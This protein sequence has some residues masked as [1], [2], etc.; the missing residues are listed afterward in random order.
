MKPAARMKSFLLLFVGLGVLAS[1]AERLGSG[2]ELQLPTGWKLTP[3][4]PGAMLSPPSHDTE[5]EMYIAGGDP[6]A[7]NLDDPQLL[8]QLMSRYFP[9]VSATPVGAPTPFK[10]VGGRGMAYV[11]SA[12]SGNEPA[13]ISL[14]LVGLDGGIGVLAAIG[15][16]DPIT[17]RGADLLAIATTFRGQL[18][19]PKPGTALSSNW[20]QRLS[21]K[22]LVQFSGYSSGGNSGGMNSQ[23]T[24]YL[25]ATETTPSA[26]RAPSR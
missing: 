20:T 8:A 11:Y 12:R 5:S 3:T 16:P 23:K 10:A 4:G 1:G 7:K 18:V 13:R 25:S 19:G 24:L 9:G 17:R 15:R 14:Y 22:K 21:D 2:L 6:E 26:R